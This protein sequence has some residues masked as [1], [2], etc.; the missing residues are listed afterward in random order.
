MNETI[1]T[2][3]AIIF[4]LYVFKDVIIEN[5]FRIL[6]FKKEYQEKREAR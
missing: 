3:M 1:R 2:I 4:T 6:M 5:V